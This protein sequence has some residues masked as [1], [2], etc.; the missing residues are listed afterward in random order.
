MKNELECRSKRMC[1]HVGFYVIQYIQSCEMR[2][3]T[4]PHLRW[5]FPLVL[6]STCKGAV[7][8]AIGVDSGPYDLVLSYR[9]ISKICGSLSADVVDILLGIPI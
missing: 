1:S 8:S 6:E 7:G 3:G 5:I 2:L 9:F 4:S